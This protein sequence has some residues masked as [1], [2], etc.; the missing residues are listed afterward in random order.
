MTAEDAYNLYWSLN[1][2]TWKAT[3]P[4]VQRELEMARWDLVV[5]AIYKSFEQ[6]TERLRQENR[7]LKSAICRTVEA[8]ANA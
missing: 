1:A 7:D 6:E 3:G 2:A 4:L 8:D 5:Q